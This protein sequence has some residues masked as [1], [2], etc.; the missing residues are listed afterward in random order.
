MVQTRQ[1]IILAGDESRLLPLYERL[2]LG[3]RASVV[4]LGTAEPDGIVGLLALIGGL[5]LVEDAGEAPPADLWIC[6]DGWRARAGA[7]P[8][9]NFEEAE[10]RWPAQRSRAGGG[11]A[12]AARPPIGDVVIE[13]DAERL[14]A[15]GDSAF[16]RELQREILRSKRY[17]LGFTL[18]LIRVLDA[19]GE[20]LSPIAFEREPLLSLPARR[21]RACDSWGLS[22]EGYLLHLAPE[23]LEQATSL[24]KRLRRALEEELAERPGGPWR[25]VGASA[26]YPRDAE[27]GRELIKTALERLERRIAIAERGEDDP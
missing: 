7:T 2:R 1:R 8:C 4:G 26:C 24:L 6:D 3:G 18:S 14:H 5:P 25:V 23:T 10:R 16:P 21:G 17:H 27:R 20:T 9:L 19:A 22:R 12:Q 13:E 15:A 11:A